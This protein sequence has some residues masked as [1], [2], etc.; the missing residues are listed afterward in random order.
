MILKNYSDYFKN[1]TFENLE[2]L[3]DSLFLYDFENYQEDMSLIF[4][5]Y[6]KTK[7]T[8]EKSELT[9]NGSTGAPKLFH[10]GPN[11]S[12]C[13]GMV[14][15]KLRMRNYK[16]ILVWNPV[17]GNK[18]NL[19]FKI[20]ES[21]NNKMDFDVVG[22]WSFESHISK[23]ILFLD[24]CFLKWGRINVLSLPHIWICLTT[25]PKF[26]SWVEDNSGKINAFVNTD[27]DATFKKT[28]GIHILDQMIDWSTGIN[29]YTCNH[30][31]RHFLPIFFKEGHESC[32]LLN[33]T[34]NKFK[35]DDEFLLKDFKKC[36]CGKNTIAFDFLSHKSNRVIDP[37]GKAVDFQGFFD[38]L[39]HHFLS[40]QL[41]QDAN[42]KVVVFYCSKQNVDDDLSKIDLF[43]RQRNIE[44]IAFVR[45]K[46]FQIGRK[47][48]SFW[49]SKELN[50]IAFSEK[51][52][53]K[54][55]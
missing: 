33:L 47:R 1:Q 8:Q 28:N 36:I 55:I 14:E 48:P 32:N 15:A 41:H 11:C 26:R 25:N 37:E 30:G 22:E 49:R 24:Y 20:S 4:E 35:V 18:S 12:D 23:L 19:R 53:P 54:L 27:C 50:V 43:L 38:M 40:L 17:F 2:K 42:G 45:S 6:K 29:F 44:K 46:Y 34:K 10:F 16:T 39:D 7:S 21:K 51:K 5:M 3:I 13:I 52:T 9:S 31:E